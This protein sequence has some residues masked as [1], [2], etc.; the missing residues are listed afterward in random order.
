MALKSV[1]E[2]YDEYIAE[3]Q[4]QAPELTDTNEGSIIDILAGVTAAAVDEINKVTEDEFAKTFFSTAHGPEVTGGA[5][6]LQTLA[7]DHFGDAFTRPA[8]AK[9]TGTITFSRPNT[10]AGNVSILAG[11]IVKTLPNA[12]GV[13]QRFE[14]TA[15]VTLTGLTINASVR[16][17]VAGPDGNILAGKATVIETTLTDNTVTVTNAAAF[18]GGSAAE[19]DAE[20]RETIRLLIETIRGA[21]KAAI[22]SKALSVAGVEHAFAAEFLQYVKEWDIAAAATVGSYFGIPRVKLYIAD[23]NGVASQT[24]I[25]DVTDAIELTRAA[26]VRIEVVAAVALLQ[27]WTA[28]ITLNPSGPNFATLQTDTSM[29]EDDMREYIQNLAIGEDFVRSSANAYMFAK[30]GPAG[31][32]DL[33]AFTTSAPSGDVSVSANQKMIPDTMGIG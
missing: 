25:D 23:A 28:S 22:E 9:S 24:L 4:A 33:T 21:T 15:G 14:V 19:N 10:N 3:L 11:T 20:Y 32:D 16:A 13:S 30:W 12:S 26:G 17:I 2:L 29:I 8:A 5:D 31:T 7:V 1:Q 6:D 18:A 27:S